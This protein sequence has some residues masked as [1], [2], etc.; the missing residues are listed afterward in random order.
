MPATGTED[1]A[2]P[3]DG[4]SSGIVDVEG[5][6]SDLVLL[7]EVRANDLDIEDDFSHITIESTDPGMATIVGIVAVHY[8]PRYADTDNTGL[9]PQD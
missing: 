3:F 9:L 4:I 1:P 2:I 5:S 7:I 6:D 8:P